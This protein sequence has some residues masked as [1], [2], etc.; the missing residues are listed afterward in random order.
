MLTVFPFSQCWSNN[1]VFQNWFGNQRR[2]DFKAAKLCRHCRYFKA[3]IDEEKHAVSQ[4]PCVSYWSLPTVAPP[5]II[6]PQSTAKPYWSPSEV[7]SPVDSVVD[8]PQGSEQFISKLEVDQVNLTAQRSMASVAV[9]SA[10]S[11]TVQQ[12]MYNFQQPLFNHEV[13]YLV[14]LILL[15]EINFS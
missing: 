1:F 8:E 12:S 2:R 4:R 13:V 9:P 10:V 14:D 6:A 5:P 3:P 15:M 7:S 11:L